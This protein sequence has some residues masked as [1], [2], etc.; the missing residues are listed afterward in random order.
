MSVGSVPDLVEEAP[1]AP[2]PCR[3]GPVFSLA[4]LAELDPAFAAKGDGSPLTPIGGLRC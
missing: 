4:E 1:K 3:D 2:P